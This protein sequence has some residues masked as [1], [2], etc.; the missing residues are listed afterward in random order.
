VPDFPN[1]QKVI[2]TLWKIGKSGTAAYGQAQ[3]AK[4]WEREA[5]ALIR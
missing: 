1:F 3:M 5:N 2:A 4:L